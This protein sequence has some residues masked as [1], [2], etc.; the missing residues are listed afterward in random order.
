MHSM[1]STK[2]T[3]A[4]A[5]YAEVL[6]LLAA[7]YDGLYTLDAAKLREVFS[8]SAGYATIRDGSLV[9]LSMDEYLPL[10]ADRTPPDDDGTPYAYRVVSIRFAGEHTALAELECS[11]FGHDYTDFLSLL[12]IDDRWRIQSKVFEGVAHE[13]N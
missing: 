11:L 7:Y 9:A 3:A 1:T 13:V 8:P 2:T 10:L 6:H 5:R 4:T 12:R